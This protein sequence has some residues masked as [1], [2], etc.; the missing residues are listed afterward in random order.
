MSVRPSKS[1]TAL[2]VMDVQR[3]AVAY[4]GEDPAFLGRLSNVIATARK[5]GLSVIHVMVHFREGYPEV[6]PHNRFLSSYLAAGALQMADMAL[7]PAVAPQPGEAIV[8]KVRSSAFAGSDLEVIL[9]S[10]AISHLVLCGITTSNVVLATLLEAADKDYD[11]TV[12]SDCCADA[13]EDVQ[14]VLMTKVFPRCAEVITAD[15]WD[16]QVGEGAS[17]FMA[18]NTFIP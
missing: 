16:K 18:G 14:H 17:S 12:L 7:H 6:S 4:V 11:L 1:H 10:Q 15:V 3:T 9:R 2:V 5:A 8:T 13:E